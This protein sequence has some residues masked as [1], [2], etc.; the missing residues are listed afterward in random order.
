[1]LDI[2]MQACVLIQ[3]KQGAASLMFDVGMQACVLIQRKQGAACLMLDIG[4]Q[5][6][7]LIQRKQGAASLMLDIGMQACVL[8]QR[9]QG[10]AS[11]MFDVAGQ[12]FI[13]NPL[14]G[15]SKRTFSRL[16]SLSCASKTTFLEHNSCRLTV[17]CLLTCQPSREENV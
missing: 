5:A 16:C 6:C 15:A 2:G 12:V 4:M 10:A 1:M 3:R 7:V 8:I 13:Q 9:K 14:I 11:L 17:K